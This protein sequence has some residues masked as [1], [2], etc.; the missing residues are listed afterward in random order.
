VPR[1]RVVHNEVAA[2]SVGLRIR[3]NDIE[4]E[5]APPVVV[6]E[7]ETLAGVV[8]VLLVHAHAEPGAL[9]ERDGRSELADGKCRSRDDAELPGEPLDAIA[10]ECDI[11][12]RAQRH[13]ADAVPVAARATHVL[14]IPTGCQ[15]DIRT[16]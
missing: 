10:T 11:G 12:S 5:H 8:V 15:R 6:D 1:V 4:I 9:V 7:G 14:T 13:G 2:G 16:N 3:G